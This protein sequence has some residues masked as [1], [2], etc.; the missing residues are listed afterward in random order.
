VCSCGAGTHPRIV[1]GDRQ[2]GGED[3]RSSVVCVHVCQTTVN[4]AK[5]AERIK[6]MEDSHHMGPRNH[7][8]HWECRYPQ[9]NLRG[10]FEGTRY[11]QSD[12]RR[13]GLLVTVTVATCSQSCP[14]VGLTHRLGRVGSRFF[15]F[16]SDGLGRV[17]YSKSTKIWKSV[18]LMHLRHG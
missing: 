6:M 18:M 4:P 1:P 11:T 12:S 9:R 17:H 7:V 13:C 3:L 10:T 14:W 15:S 5:T 8:M 2:G 16:W